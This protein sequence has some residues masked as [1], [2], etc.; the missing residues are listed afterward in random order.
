MIF[1]PLDD[2]VPPLR[3]FPLVVG[4]CG[5]P[6]L[7]HDAEGGDGS[8]RVVGELWRVDEETLEV[9]RC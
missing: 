9:R 3:R 8:F 2:V 7:L 5:V 6:Y 1:V 4:R